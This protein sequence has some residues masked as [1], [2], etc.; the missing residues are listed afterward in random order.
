MAFN[1]SNK[2]EATSF[3]Q[4]PE[5]DYEV[6]VEKAEE[7]PTKSG[8]MQLSIQLRIRDD[9]EQACKKRMLFLNI[10]Q[11][12]P[13]KLTDADRQVENYNYNHLYHLLDMTGILRSG[14][15]FD[16]MADICRLLAGCEMRVTVYYENWNGRLQERIDPLKGVHESDPDYSTPPASPAY[17]APPSYQPPQPPVNPAPAT[18][19]DDFEDLPSDDDLPF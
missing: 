11:K 13:E 9:V 7:R 18:G 16:S 15:S 17:S 6:F 8:R 5:G 1:F 2:P 14:K 19:F 4:I 12:T 3:E 10:F